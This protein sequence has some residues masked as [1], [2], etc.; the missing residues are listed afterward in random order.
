MS[1]PTQHSPVEDRI[2]QAP[3]GPGRAEQ[4]VRGSR[5]LADIRPVEEEND[6]ADHL[7]ALREEF[8]R[9]THHCWGWRLWL[10]GEVR[11]RSGDEP[12]AICAQGG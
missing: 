12:G 10:D 5:F 1:R 11:E 9:A 3:A 7:Q 2:W 8:P 6:A 4:K